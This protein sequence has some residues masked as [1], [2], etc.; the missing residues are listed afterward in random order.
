MRHRIYFEHY[1]KFIIIT[2]YVNEIIRLN[3]NN[4][5]KLRVESSSVIIQP[6]F[7]FKKKKKK[8]LK[9]APKIILLGNYLLKETEG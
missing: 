5:S 8:P 9:Q 3:L 6:V 2:G 1:F 4:K 7:Y